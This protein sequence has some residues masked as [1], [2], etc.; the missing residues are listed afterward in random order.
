LW[1]QAKARAKWEGTILK[2][3]TRH[4]LIREI[5]GLLVDDVIMTTSQ[6]L[7]KD[8][9]SSPEDIQRA[10]YGIVGYSD[11]TAKINR[12]L[13]AFL[14]EQMYYHFRIVRMSQRAEYFLSG[15]F[16]TMV[17]NPRQ[18]PP[19]YQAAIPEEGVHRIVADYI[20][21]LTDR[22]ALLEYRRLYDPLVRP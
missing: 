5:V 16:E 15:I 8:R 11:A 12:E 6:R 18:L 20:A 21:S 1:Q 4:H 13:K 3:V 14:Y 10:E 7:T 2:D 22:S 19:E 9:V 17:K